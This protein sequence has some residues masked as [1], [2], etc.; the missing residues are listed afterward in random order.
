MITFDAQNSN[1]FGST[2]SSITISL[3]VGNN[4]NRLLVVGVM[5]EEPGAP[6]GNLVVSG[7]TYDGVA[8][9]KIDADQETGASTTRC[10]LWY[11]LNP[12]TGTHN[13]VITFTGSIQGAFG[14]AISYYGV[15]QVAPEI[16]AKAHAT[17]TDPTVTLITSASN[18]LVVDSVVNGTE[19]NTLTLDSGTQRFNTNAGTILDAGMSEVIQATPGSVSRNW[20]I[21][22]SSRWAQVAASFAPAIAT[23]IK[24]VIGVGMIPH[25]RG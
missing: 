7:I 22:A 13:V 3:T 14:G 10:E 23:R 5:S 20:T 19:G 18:A 2:G 9:T 8:L 24:D 12:N 25:R 15:K 16:S 6:T 4:N 17:G 21:S 1:S 11:L